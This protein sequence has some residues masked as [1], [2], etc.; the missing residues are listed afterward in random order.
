MQYGFYIF[1]RPYLM[2]SDNLS[3]VQSKHRSGFGCAVCVWLRADFLQLGRMGP[4]PCCGEAVLIAW[5][6]LLGGAWA[7]REGFSSCSTQAS[8][9]GR[10][11]QGAWTSLVATH[12]LSCRGLWALECVGFSNCAP[13]PGCPTAWLLLVCESSPDQGSTL[14]LL[15]CQADSCLLPHREVLTYLLNLSLGFVAIVS[16]HHPTPLFFSFLGAYG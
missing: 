16:G 15:H 8:G 4:S 7:R 9:C 2:S 3:I 14:G 5:P 12:R 10:R 1:S 6:P 11:L 13:W